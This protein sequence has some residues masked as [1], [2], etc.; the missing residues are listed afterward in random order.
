M[1]VDGRHIDI[2]GERAGFGRRRIELKL[3]AHL[4]EAA[5]E[6]RQTHMLDLE[7][8]LRVARIDL[9]GALLGIDRTE[10]GNAEADGGNRDGI[11]KRGDLRTH[12]GTPFLLTES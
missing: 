6:V 7:D 3:A 10:G 12:A 9:V 8:D 4:G 11:D 2:G 5:E 1:R